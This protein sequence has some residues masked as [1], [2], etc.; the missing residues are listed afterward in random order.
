MRVVV[1]RDGP[2]PEGFELGEPPSDS[3]WNAYRWREPKPGE[4]S[5]FSHGRILDA[6]I[7]RG[8]R[9]LV[10][11]DGSSVNLDHTVTGEK[12]LNLLREAARDGVEGDL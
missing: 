10:R 11:A 9:L 8:I 5:T 12:L 3:D 4:K 2:P 1:W 7:W 6:H